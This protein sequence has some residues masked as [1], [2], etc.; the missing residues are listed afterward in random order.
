MK[1]HFD[2]SNFEAN[3]AYYEPG[4]AANKAV[5]G[6]MKDEMAGC[7]ISEVLGPSRKM[8]SVKAVW[9]NPDRKKERFG[10]HPLKGIQRAAA[11]KFLQ[12]QY[13]DLFHKPTENYALNRRLGGR[14]QQI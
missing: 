12:D 9:N 13:L 11:E 1:A 4:S 8:Y 7:R 10:K 6:K 5:G 2:M 14:L 3:N